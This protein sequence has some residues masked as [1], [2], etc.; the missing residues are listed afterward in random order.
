MEEDSVKH[1]DILDFANYYYLHDGTYPG[2][3]IFQN[4]WTGGPFSWQFN[5]PLA[6][7][8]LNRTTSLYTHDSTVSESESEMI[9]SRR[10]GLYNQV[11]LYYVLP[12]VQQKKNK[13]NQDKNK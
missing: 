13:I 2:V 7:L 6:L 11:I 1:G 12:Y 5:D 9:L 10:K 4:S 8:I 3:Q